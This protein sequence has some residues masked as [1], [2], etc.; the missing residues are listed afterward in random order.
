M[1]PEPENTDENKFNDFN[2]DDDNNLDLPMQKIMERTV[3]RP[4]IGVPPPG[5]D[6]NDEYNFEDDDYNNGVFQSNENKK[7]FDNVNY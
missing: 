7:I 1:C 6:P 4:T 3:E 2:N 5:T